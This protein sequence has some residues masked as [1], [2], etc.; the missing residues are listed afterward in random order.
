MTYW[1]SWVVRL[2]Q[3][4][5]GSTRHAAKAAGVDYSH[6]RRGLDGTGIKP[7]PASLRAGLSAEY[8][9]RCGEAASGIPALA[10]IT[11][12][13]LRDMYNWQSVDVTAG[14][15]TAII[16]DYFLNLL[17]PDEYRVLYPK[18]ETL[19]AKELFFGKIYRMPLYIADCI[20]KI[21]G[22]ITITDSFDDNMNIPCEAYGL[23]LPSIEGLKN[24]NIYPLVRS[25]SRCVWRNISE[26]DPPNYI[27][28]GHNLY[29]HA[30]ELATNWKLQAQRSLK[31]TAPGE[32]HSNLGKQLKLFLKNETNIESDIHIIF[33]ILVCANWIK[34]GY[35]RTSERNGFPDD[36]Y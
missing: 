27:E 4:V 30:Q 23:L 2:M 5:D 21:V 8:L 25:Q 3:L 11:P 20:K 28:I 16:V 7:L 14:A 35:I 15:Y 18:Y 17:A 10:D 26:S 33:K 19:F 29:F 12:T 34:K 32:A 22:N 9:R 6:L 1:A 31:A 36:R 24:Y 13:P